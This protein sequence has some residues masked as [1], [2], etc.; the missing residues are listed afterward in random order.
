MIFYGFGEF[1]ALDVRENHV[2]FTV[3]L[4]NLHVLLRN[5]YT[6]Y[7]LENH[8]IVST[9]SKADLRLVSLVNFPDSRGCD[10]TMHFH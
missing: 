4:V 8:R 9:V 5:G 6:M 3:F 1:C 7:F 2:F 10:D